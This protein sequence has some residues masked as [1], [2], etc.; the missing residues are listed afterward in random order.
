MIT[1]QSILQSEALRSLVKEYT[2]RWILYSSGALGLYDNLNE[3][4]FHR[5]VEPNLIT[6]INFV[7]D[8]LVDSYTRENI[9]RLIEGSPN[10]Q[11]VFSRI[12]INEVDSFEQLR[13]FKNLKRLSISTEGKLG[14]EIV[15]KYL[16][17]ESLK[18]S[19]DNADLTYLAEQKS[20][21]QLEISG[22][23]KNIQ[24]VGSLVNLN[25][26]ILKHQTLKAI[27]F[28]FSLNE[29][30]EIHFQLG[31]KPNLEGIENV[32]NLERLNFWHVRQLEID[33]LL[34]V[35]NMN[36]LLALSLKEQPRISSIDWLDAPNLKYLS[37]LG[38]RGFKTLNGLSRFN[39]LETFFTVEVPNEDLS[40]ILKLKKL[41]K[42]WLPPDVYKRNEK[43]IK[44]VFPNINITS[45]E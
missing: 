18:I 20:I 24:A 45:E 14:I 22:K 36:N 10:L 8:F 44:G 15:N 42:L 32:V 13:F 29:L 26:L 31:G 5:L 17:L 39:K 4:D 25:S 6:N 16:S 11:Y 12:G 43:L 7:S 41:T 35:N 27:D 19:G 23:V 28:L 37:L 38:L 30:K 33:N 34:P 1:V 21:K 3:E 40:E 9:Y 2:D